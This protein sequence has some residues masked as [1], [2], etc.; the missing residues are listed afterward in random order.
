MTDKY[1]A[2][3]RI[4]GATT[5]DKMTKLRAYSEWGFQARAKFFPIGECDE[6]KGKQA[7]FAAVFWLKFVNFY[8]IAKKSEQ[9]VFILV[10]YDYSMMGSA[11]SVQSVA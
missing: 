1:V 6:I 10:V 9:I 8:A 7:K 2:R 11:M 4:F 3:G 5:L